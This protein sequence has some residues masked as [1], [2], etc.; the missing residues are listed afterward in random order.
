VNATAFYEHDEP[1]GH[2]DYRFPFLVS[3]GLSRSPRLPVDLDLSTIGYGAIKEAL[4]GSLKM[5]TLAEVGVRLGHYRT[6]IHYNGKAISAHI[7]L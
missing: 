6:I 1:I 2:I 4:G 7:R 3:P 5:N